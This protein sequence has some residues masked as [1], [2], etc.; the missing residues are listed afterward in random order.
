MA[1]TNRQVV[2]GS[3]PNQS[4]DPRDASAFPGGQVWGEQGEVLLEATLLLGPGDL[5]EPLVLVQII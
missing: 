5:I 1:L 3:F 2:H 4:S